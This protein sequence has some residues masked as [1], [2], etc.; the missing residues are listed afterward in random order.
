MTRVIAME[1]TVCLLTV[2]MCRQ[3]RVVLGMTRR[4]GL[5]KRRKNRR[6]TPDQKEQE[7]DGEEEQD[8]S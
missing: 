1:S 5:T 3:L 2:H 7:E 8:F 4:R 6:T